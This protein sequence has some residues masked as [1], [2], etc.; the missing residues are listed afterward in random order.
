MDFVPEMT[1]KASQVDVANSRDGKQFDKTTM[2][3]Q[4]GWLAAKTQTI[5]VPPTTAEKK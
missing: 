5:L 2:T 1:R 4:G 3:S